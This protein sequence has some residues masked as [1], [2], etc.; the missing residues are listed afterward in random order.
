MDAEFFL[1]QFGHLAQ[2]E[3]GI[4]KL[5]DV[6]LQLAVRGKLVEQNPADEP[7]EML[8]KKIEVEKKRLV[9]EESKG[10]HKA[11]IDSRK[12]KHPFTIPS[13]WRWVKFPQ[14]VHFSMGKTPSRDNA[15]F[16]AS[17]DYPW[18]SI[19]DLKHLSTI[20][21]T[22]EKISKL[23]AD[24]CFSG[25]IA[26]KGS[27]LMSFKLTIGKTSFLDMDAFH[28]EAI[29]SIFPYIDEIK[30]FMFWALSGID[31]T[32]D[33]SNA[34]KGN[35]L[36]RE[37]I[38]NLLFPLPPLSEQ[39]RIV[40][41]INELMAL[42]DKL[43]AEQKAQA[44]LKTQAVKSTL[45]HITDAA[46]SKEFA[47]SF[48]I[49]TNK[50]GP[51]FDDLSNVKNLRATI[52]QLA[53]QG[54]LV[55]QN[56]ADEP[57]SELLKR[58]ETE[59]KR[60]VK[61]GKIKA[62]K[63]L[64]AIKGSEAPFELPKGWEWARLDNLATLITKGS[65]PKWQGVDYLDK[66]LLF[67][68][69]ENVGAYELLLHKRKYVDPKFNEI[70]P[71]SILQKND[72]LMNIVGASIGRTAIYNIDEIANINQAV[73]LI[74]I[75]QNIVDNQFFLHFC[76]SNH[77][78]NQMFDKQVDNARANLSMGNIAKFAVPIPPLAAQKR[79][80]TKVDELMKLC[81]QL[82]SQITQSQTLNAHLMDSLIHRITEAA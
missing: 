59:K 8:L 13:S 80:V 45:H 42:C 63:P 67:I 66:G 12:D 76:N 60:L 50:F 21:H 82:E 51:W 32:K 39:K 37:I 4:K 10:K 9:K 56:P 17:G 62:S 27:L 28:N 52:L 47:S 61:E 79:I 68:T 15:S 29:I 48:N 54:K 65:S 71:R 26:P 53:V 3:G 35:T 38:E 73:C 2:S 74:R 64:P 49:L 57:A 14:I 44:T 75:V 24:N 40:S 58:I 72:I 6:I 1:K 55:P 25:Q 33:Q 77:C 34:I 11:I 43:E 23:A 69:S 78:I 31:L 18:V 36:N 5:R 22:K 41:R 30:F 70:E 7:A 16:W 20:S 81:D 19:A 46:N